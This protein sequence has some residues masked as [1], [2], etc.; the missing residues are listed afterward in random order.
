MKDL[1]FGSRSKKRDG[2]EKQQED[3]IVFKVQE[4]WRYD[5][6]IGVRCKEM[7]RKMMRS[8]HVF[9][10]LLS[11]NLASLPIYLCALC[12]KTMMIIRI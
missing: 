12:N 3:E 6:D 7:A 1:A 4:N 8:E 9:M 5:D 11:L 10:S 2:N